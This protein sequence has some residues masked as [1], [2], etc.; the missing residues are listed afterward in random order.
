[1]PD[2][3]RRSGSPLAQIACLFVAS[4][5][6]LL[7]AG[8][9]ATW[10]LPSGR[11]VQGGNLVWHQAAPRALE[12]WARWDAEWYLLIA[13][14]GYEVGPVLARFAVDYE[15]AA[16]AGFLP[17]YPLLIRSLAPLLGGIAA[18]VLISNLALLASLLLLHRLVALE[19]GGE[20]GGT[21]GLAAC[22]ALLLHPSS[23]FLSAVYAESLFLALSLGT[24][25]AARSG[26]FAAAGALGGLAALTRPF[27]L[28]LL[29][30]VVWEGWAGWR[31]RDGGSPRPVRWWTLA[32]AALIPAALGAYLLFCRS[33][34]GDPLALLHRQ[35][36]WRGG[37]SGP[38]RAFVRWWEAGPSAHG[39]HGS[40]FELV[41]A[42]LCLAGLALML[43]R[44]RAPYVLYTAAAMT[45]ALGST[46]WSFSRLSLTLFPFAMLLGGLWADNRRCVPVLYAFA[47]A[48]VGGLLMALFAT[49][50]WAG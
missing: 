29:I 11:A 13:D 2:R 5:L 40:T 3:P 22:A 30:P 45:V 48:T 43:R 36:R 50:W 42:V 1:M 39:S 15:P 9:L 12:I 4:R 8:L 10:L 26:R 49:G 16:A 20:T 6:A 19:V 32:W 18:G 14:R 27:G 21:A 47:G 46:L 7:A 33:V 35:E 23:L 24:F 41:V 37:L 31:G 34:F 38:W 44:L 17:L 28:L 25:L